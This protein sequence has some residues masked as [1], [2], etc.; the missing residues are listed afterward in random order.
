MTQID[1]ELEERVLSNV[2][3]RQ[4]IRSISLAGDTD[5]AESLVRLQSDASAYKNVGANTLQRGRAS[6]ARGQVG[7]SAG[8]SVTSTGVSELSKAGAVGSAGVL[9]TVEGQAEGSVK[10]KVS[11]GKRKRRMLL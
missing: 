11:V 10:W 1:S 4:L 6:S 8:R 5:D 2:D 9:Q 7:S 3:D